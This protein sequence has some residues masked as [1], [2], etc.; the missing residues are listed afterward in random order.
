MQETL[1]TVWKKIWIFLFFFF[2]FT[3]WSKCNQMGPFRVVISVLFW[4]PVSKGEW[5]KFIID[6]F[7]IVT[8]LLLFCQNISKL[9]TT[10]NSVFALLRSGQ[11]PQT[12]MAEGAFV[13]LDLQRIIPWLDTRLVLEG[14]RTLTLVVTSLAR[15]DLPQALRF[16]ILQTTQERTPK[17]ETGFSYPS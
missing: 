10:P 9:V 3:E 6:S 15:Q 2:F 4:W 11:C 16:L 7:V 1:H 17:D 12:M 8:Y 5:Q 14:V 13:N